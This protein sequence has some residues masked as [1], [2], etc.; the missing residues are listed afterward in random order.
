MSKFEIIKKLGKG[1]FASVYQV[2]RKEDNQQYAMKRVSFSEMSK[3]DKERALNEIRVLV[4]FNHPNIISYKESFYSEETRTLD[5]IM[6]Y[7]EE[8]DILSMI[9]KA[10]M[11]KAIISE[12]RI[13]TILIQI[14][15]G[16]KALH[17]KKFIHRDLKS[18]NVFL[19]KG[20]IAKIGDFNVAKRLKTTSFL[21]SQTGTPYYAAPEIWLEKPYDM[22]S[23]I[24]SLG[25]I[26]YEMCTL[27]VP[28]QAHSIPQLCKAIAKG[29]YKPISL[30]YSKS[31][32]II[33]S[34]LLVT[35]I[36]KRKT[37][38][39]MLKEIIM[40]KKMEM[41]NIID[42]PCT[43]DLMDTIKLPID[44]NN[45]NSVLPKITKYTIKTPI[46]FLSNKKIIKNDL[47]FHSS[48]FL[49]DRFGKERALS[50][51]IIGS[52][53]QFNF[54]N[55]YNPIFNSNKNILKINKP[56]LKNIIEY[57]EENEQDP[58]KKDN[59]ETLRESRYREEEE[60]NEKNEG[61]A[62]NIIQTNGKISI[63]V[64]R[65]LYE[66]RINNN[67]KFDNAKAYIFPRYK[68]VLHN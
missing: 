67:Q 9:K 25:C 49:M 36:Y 26:V 42:I 57:K 47:P 33:L 39:E 13:W 29:E 68:K 48:S 11:N 61:E 21:Q 24:W 35:D 64:N 34:K 27:Q 32:E 8:G 56:L 63:R 66:R 55:E 44:D 5:I 17:E 12:R 22:R 50:T 18:A 41:L 20:N 46:I 3:N 40:T 60:E 1:S 62:A 59:K 52:L 2:I 54:H 45:F 10:K 51:K 65:I 14:L 6:E 58:I 31:L 43:S 7:A 30:I 19:C 4:S 28:F 53:H 37:S 16:L 15:F 38:E 23:D